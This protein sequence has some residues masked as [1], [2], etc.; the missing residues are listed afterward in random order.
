MEAEANTKATPNLR[1]AASGTN[2]AA[3]ANASG[4]DAEME[5]FEEVNLDDLEADLL[6]LFT[7][8]QDFWPA[9]YGNCTY[10]STRVRVATTKLWISFRSN[11]SINARCFCLLLLEGDCNTFLD[12]LCV[13]V[14]SSR[15]PFQTLHSLSALLGIAPV[16]IVSPMVAVVA[17]VGASDLS[18]S[19]RGTTTPTWTKHGTCCNLSSSSECRCHPLHL[20]VW[21]S[22]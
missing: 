9:D 18:Q 19:C 15:F 20:S 14:L 4:E 6:D 12:I 7:N 1:S 17:T 10:S 21:I 16:A 11:T 3:D 5:A 8:S 22:M 13:F 2:S